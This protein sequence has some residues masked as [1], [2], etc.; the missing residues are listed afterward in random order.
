MAVP[1]RYGSSLSSNPQKQFYIERGTIFVRNYNINEGAQ[2]ADLDKMY[3]IKYV[4]LQADLQLNHDVS[5]KKFDESLEVDIKF[6]LR[7][8]GDVVATDTYLWVQFKNI[9]EIVRCTGEWADI[10]YYNKNV[11]TIQLVY[12]FPVI[13]LIPPIRMHCNGAV[14]KVDSA[15]ERIEA[16][17]IMGATNMRTKEGTYVISLKEQT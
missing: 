2:R 4:T 13:P 7:N 10:S 15:V 8:L 14:V 5:I 12:G 11:P 16:H 17:V 3:K 9:K 1:D 6:L